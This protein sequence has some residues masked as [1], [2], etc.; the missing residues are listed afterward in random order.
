M[1]VKYRY[2]V[3]KGRNYYL[4]VVDEQLMLDESILNFK[5]RT[6]PEWKYRENK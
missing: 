5:E 3:S 6:Y 4:V 1:T 2:K